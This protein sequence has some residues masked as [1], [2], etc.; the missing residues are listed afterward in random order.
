MEKIL[1]YDIDA[2]VKNETEQKFEA[3]RYEKAAIF[4]GSRGVVLAEVEAVHKRGICMTDSIAIP[5]CPI[6]EEGRMYVASTHELVAT[7]DEIVAKAPCTEMY[8]EEFFARRDYNPRC[9]DNYATLMRTLKDI[10]FD[11][12]PYLREQLSV[13]EQINKAEEQQ[14]SVREKPDC[15]LIGADGNIFNLMSIA[16]RTLQK[17]GMSNEATEMC[18]RIRSSG[19]YDE[20]LCILGEYV[21]ITSVEEKQKNDGFDRESL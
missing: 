20:A 6:P 3:F 19:S 13:S 21:N 9:Q 4:L 2:F 11:V 12:L 1:V 16:S 15:P 17:N 7:F 5:I 18:E 10:G 8:M 14:R